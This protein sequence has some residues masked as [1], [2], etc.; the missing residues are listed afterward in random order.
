MSPLNRDQK[1]ALFDHT[2]GLASEPEDRQ[3]EEVI[4]SNYKAAEIHSQLKAVLF[5]LDMQ[6]PETCPDDLVEKMLWRPRQLA[7][8]EQSVKESIVVTSRCCGI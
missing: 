5:A 2:F 4:A 1:E 3:A 7:N 8:S 6:K